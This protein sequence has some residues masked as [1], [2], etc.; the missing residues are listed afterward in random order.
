MQRNLNLFLIIFC[1]LISIKN[2]SFSDADYEGVARI[3][4]ELNSLNDSKFRD[5]FG[6]ISRYCFLE[7]STEPES[8]SKCVQKF[9]K[10]Y[11]YY[12]NQQVEEDQCSV[13]DNSKGAV[14]NN[15]LNA[16][17]LFNIAFN[18]GSLSSEFVSSVST[19]VENIQ[20]GIS[21]LDYELGTVDHNFAQY[22]G[23]IVK[24][25]Y[26]AASDSPSSLQKCISAVIN[27]QRESGNAQASQNY[28]NQQ[29]SSQACAWCDNSKGIVYEN[30]LKAAKVNF[31]AFPCQAALTNMFN[32][33][34]LPEIK[35][36]I[37]SGA[38]VTA[39]SLYA[40]AG[41]TPGSN[42]WVSIGMEAGAYYSYG[43]GESTNI[44][45]DDWLCNPG[46]CKASNTDPV[47]V[48]G[49][50]SAS[51][52]FSDFS[53]KTPTISIQIPI[54]FKMKFSVL[55]ADASGTSW[56]GGIFDLDYKFISY[57][58]LPVTIEVGSTNTVKIGSASVNTVLANSLDNLIGGIWTNQGVT[59]GI[60]N[61]KIKPNIMKQLNKSLPK[62]QAGI[63]SN[64]S[65]A[66]GSI[67]NK[68]YSFKF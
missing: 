32:I 11:P 52:I 35:S 65:S 34:V 55:Y 31:A 51:L 20:S 66:V 44:S 68:Q 61:W 48:I 53:C 15:C 10:D 23:P 46:G 64:V 21:K 6:W 13:C 7:N 8:Y 4:A 26:M 47:I 60:Y 27:E 1:C 14:Y 62:I 37:P 22:Y 50:P 42:G 49:D 43:F 17:K 30:C 29:I 25:C 56:T 19:I 39:A 28:C 38:D 63:N 33:K 24:A 5:Y 16:I 57:I 67:A 59:S 3:Q 2:L 41:L 12:C 58:D 9:S 18:P 54:D 40:Q 36:K 45:S